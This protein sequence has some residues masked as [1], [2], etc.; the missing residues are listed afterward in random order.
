[1]RRKALNGESGLGLQLSP[2]NHNAYAPKQRSFN[3]LVSA[4]ERAENGIEGDRYTY[5]EVLRLDEWASC[6]LRCTC[7][8]CSEGEAVELKCEAYQFGAR[9]GLMH[10]VRRPHKTEAVH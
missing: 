3:E 9:K 5:P 10:E 7:R 6:T 8:A 4:W 1:M 2:E